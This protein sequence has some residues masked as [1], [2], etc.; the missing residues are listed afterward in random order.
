MFVIHVY[1]SLT[2][3]CAAPS[4]NLPPTRQSSHPWRDK[5]DQ[6]PSRITEVN[7]LTALRPFDFFFNDDAVALQV[8]PPG[9]ERLSFNSESDHFGGVLACARFTNEHFPF[10]RVKQTEPESQS[11]SAFRL[12]SQKRS[13]NERSNHRKA[14]SPRGYE[15]R[16]PFYTPNPL[17]L[18]QQHIR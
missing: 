6:I 15:L 14:D 16:R 18:L 10:C 3:S 2:P 17:E 8:P 4:F 12:L 1:Y 7:G 13:Q 9:V 11:A 5:F